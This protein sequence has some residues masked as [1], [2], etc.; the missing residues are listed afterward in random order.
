M[1]PSHG[2]IYLTNKN[3][4]QDKTRQIKR[5]RFDESKNIYLITFENSEEV[6]HYKPENVEIIRN[7]VVAEEKNRYSF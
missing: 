6:F 7:A 3:G 4:R 2:I 5:I 1:N